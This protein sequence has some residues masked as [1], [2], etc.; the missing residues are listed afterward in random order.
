MSFDEVGNPVI[1][2]VFNLLVKHET[3]AADQNVLTGDKDL[4]D[5]LVNGDY[6][7][8]FLRIYK[9]I[10]GHDDAVI[11]GYGNERRPALR[12]GMLPIP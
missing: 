1:K 8:V 12:G 4:L 3:G 10:C 6:L 11:R 7:S 2:F 5:A 9:I